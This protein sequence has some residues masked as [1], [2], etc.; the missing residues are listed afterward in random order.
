MAGSN[1][2]VPTPVV[3]AGSPRLMVGRAAVYAA[4]W[5]ASVGTIVLSVS[6]PPLR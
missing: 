2:V 5:A 4:N 1:S 3:A 6:L